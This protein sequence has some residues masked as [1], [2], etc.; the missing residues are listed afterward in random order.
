MIVFITPTIIRN[1]HEAAR[2]SQDLRDK[3]KNLNF[4]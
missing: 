3:M 2:S 4:D 1:G